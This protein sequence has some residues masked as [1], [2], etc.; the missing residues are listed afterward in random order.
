MD[1]LISLNEQ[2]KYR[3]IETGSSLA[4]LVADALHAYL[5]DTRQERTT[6]ETGERT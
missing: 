2:V 1:L 6:T 5:A 3:A 4:E